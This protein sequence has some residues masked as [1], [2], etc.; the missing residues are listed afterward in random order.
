MYYCQ[1]YKIKKWHRSVWQRNNRNLFHRA[2]HSVFPRHLQNISNEPI[3]SPGPTI[4]KHR[5]LRRSYIQSRDER[6]STWCSAKQSKNILCAMTVMCTVHRILYFRVLRA[7]YY[8][9]SVHVRCVF[10]SGPPRRRRRRSRYSW[11]SFPLSCP[12]AFMWFRKIVVFV[13]VARILAFS[14]GKYCAANRVAGLSS[15]TTTI[16][17]VLPIR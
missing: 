1:N 10:F 4:K 12:L 7:Q 8:C 5:Q 3:A 9:N 16:M 2:D 17:Y 6:S 13:S 15:T 11:S 14:G